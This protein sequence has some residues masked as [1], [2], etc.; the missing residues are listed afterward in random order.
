MAEIQEAFA[1]VAEAE[2]SE[3]LHAPTP[4]PTEFPHVVQ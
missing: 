1:K 3:T 2:T 4:K